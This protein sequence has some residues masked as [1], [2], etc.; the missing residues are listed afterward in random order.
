MQ[1]LRPVDALEC[2]LELLILESSVLSQKMEFFNKSP[3]IS[4]NSQ[5]S[6]IRL[7]VV[8]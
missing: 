7:F 6:H 8:W 4:Q 2:L 1:V 5:R 3:S